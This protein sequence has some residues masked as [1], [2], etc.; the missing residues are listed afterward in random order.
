MR[1][2]FD[3]R[4]LFHGSGLH[5]CL[6]SI[7]CTTCRSNSANHE[8]TFLDGCERSMLDCDV[9]KDMNDRMTK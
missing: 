5:N 7:A 1:C 4:H 8:I 3:E 2:F 9:F 6:G